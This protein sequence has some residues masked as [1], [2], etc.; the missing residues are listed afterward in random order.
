MNKRI[1]R[2][3]ERYVLNAQNDSMKKSLEALRQSIIRGLCTINQDIERVIGQVE[4]GNI[5]FGIDYGD[6]M[7]KIDRLLIRYSTIK[8]VHKAY[9]HELNR[10][11]NT[12]YNIED[13]K[14]EVMKINS[15]IKYIN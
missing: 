14:T 5:P 2:E 3:D 12:P 6:R 15:D 1:N 13:E 7:S 10:Q 11:I 8:D 4:R 9:E